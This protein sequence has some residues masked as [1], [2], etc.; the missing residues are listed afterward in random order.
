MEKIKE[1]V[2]SDLKKAGHFV[3]E[4]AKKLGFIVFEGAKKQINEYH[5][6]YGL[7]GLIAGVLVLLKIFLFYSFMNISTNVF[8]VWL[9]TCILVWVLFSSFRNKW[10]PLFIFTIVTLIMFAD[11]TYS[12]FFNRYLS[13]GMI[14]AAG[15]LGDIG[16]SIKEVIKPQ[17]FLLFLDV[18][19]IYATLIIGR[20]PLK[21]NK[22]AKFQEEVSRNQ[23]IKDKI[24]EIKGSQGLKGSQGIKGI[25]GVILL[26][27]LLWN[28][29]H[30][31]FAASIGNQEFFGYHIKD[32]FSGLYQEDLDSSMAAY[33]DSYNK[34]K[35]GPLFGVAKG[36]NV[37]IL[38]VE[39]LQNFVVGMEYNGQEITPNLNRLIEGNSIY[40]PQ[41][42]QQIGSGNTS[43]AEFAANNSLYGTLASYTYKLY[44]QNYYRGLPTLL[45]E[46][47]YSAN[48]FHSFEDRSFWNRENAYPALGFD[49]YYG[50]LND[51]GRDGDYTSTEWM[52]WGLTDSE[53]YPQTVKYMKE[54]SQPF[55][56]FVI[57]LSNHH[58]YEMLPEYK[59]IDLL[60]ED[61]GTIVGNYL[62][63]VA[64]TDYS[65]GIFFDELE[66]AGL[67]DNSI[68]MI[69]G[70]HVGLTHNKD[71]D[72]SMERLLGHPY[73]FQDMLNIPFIISMPG[74]ETDI[75]GIC[76][77]AGGQT[78]V[79]PTLAYLLGFP[80][81]DTL[82]VGHNILTVKEGFVAQ[83]TYMPKGSFFTNDIGYEMSRDGIFEHG[84]GW[85][86]KTGEAID[87]DK[88]KDGYLKSISIVNTS[89]YILK[90]DAIRQIYLENKSL[91]EAGAQDVGRIHPREIVDAGWPR[92]DLFRTNTIEAMDYTYMQGYHTIRINGEWNLDSE[93]YVINPN[94]GLQSLSWDELIPWM[95]E[96][97]SAQI[98][99]SIPKS[100]DYLM[101]YT[102]QKSLA[103]AANIIVEYTSPEDY[104]GRFEGILNLV[105][106]QISNEDIISFAK[107]HR[108]WAVM[109]RPEQ[110]GMIGA[111]LKA[112]DVYVYVQEEWYGIIQAGN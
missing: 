70:D 60:P 19:L 105:N 72:L 36:R 101:N 27:L 35:N 26:V 28:P 88:C 83:Q 109:L 22:G 87:L 96:H 47:G 21:K 61:E 51:Q 55:Y 68:I 95:E 52:G 29:L 18:A 44:D 53:F 66:A 32:V 40:C 24:H 67:Y 102:S 64:Y 76:E 107:N 73:G 99:V 43:D 63:S 15:V 13:I 45:K 48:V 33:T 30:S 3:F 12:S 84:R 11:V 74:G 100:G 94:T 17:F 86:L 54:Q 8:F 39:S 90:S 71:I 20:I 93:P 82:Y 104:S 56:S 38:Q 80:K 37:I 6:I 65:M 23:W 31:G 5:S 79:L 111:S 41:F 110:Y 91:T 77:T 112:D 2:S 62:N 89:E 10:I 81:L 34:E 7:I 78:D 9:T 69:Y 106:S 92:D 50:G 57:S 108:V 49:R 4:W 98:V 1:L 25:I 85:N 103:A 46:Q 42:Y 58:P 16:E 75:H 59:F 97:G 14:G